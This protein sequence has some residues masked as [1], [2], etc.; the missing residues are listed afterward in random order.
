[1]SKPTLSQV[2]AAIRQYGILHSVAEA[3]KLLSAVGGVD[4]LADLPESKFA[5]V[6]AATGVT[7]AADNRPK[8]INEAGIWN[9]WNRA[10][11]RAPRDKGG[12][13]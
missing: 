4:S 13:S 1:M 2:R 12:G 10:G 5:D 3:N 11:Q 7:G 6:I 8:A 9:H